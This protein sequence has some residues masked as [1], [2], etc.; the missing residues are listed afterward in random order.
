MRH[1]IFKGRGGSI[2]AGP[3]PLEVEAS[4]SAVGVEDLAVVEAV[5]DVLL[6]GARKEGRVDLAA[7]LAL[8]GRPC[9]AR[10]P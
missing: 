5:A 3:G 2:G 8:G 7:H 6:D 9:R 1:S 4:D 10:V